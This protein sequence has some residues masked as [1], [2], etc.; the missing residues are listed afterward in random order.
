MADLEVI[1]LPGPGGRIS[2]ERIAY[3]DI[4]PIGESLPHG[5][6]LRWN[7]DVDMRVEDD[8]VI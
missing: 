8:R 4:P 1:D 3:E 6:R 2:G 7:S 5:N